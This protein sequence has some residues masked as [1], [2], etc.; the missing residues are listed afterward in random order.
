MHLMY[1]TEQPMSAY[2]ADENVSP[3][4]STCCTASKP[5]AVNTATLSSNSR[6]VRSSRSSA[7]GSSGF[8]ASPKSSRLMVC[9]AR[10]RANIG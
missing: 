6:L 9:S 1:F 7:S 10:T 2:P 3:S 5:Y 8:I 4:F